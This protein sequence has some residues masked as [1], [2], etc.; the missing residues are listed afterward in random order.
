MIGEF[1]ADASVAVAWVHPAQSSREAS[2]WLDA[3]AAGAQ[4]IV[5]SIWSLEVSNA[6]LTLERR[7][8]LQPEERHRAL[9]FL[10]ALPVVVDHDGGA[11]AFGDLAALATRETLSVYD[12]SYLELALRR[13]LPLGCRD[14][15][16]RAAAVS[17]GLPILP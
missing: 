4:L 17:H 5:P 8:G 16:L 11:H 14:G 9:E 7:G 15:A 10:R 1:V 12:A 3:L 13:K 6:L 2:A